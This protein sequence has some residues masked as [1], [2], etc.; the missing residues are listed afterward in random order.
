MAFGLEVFKEVVDKDGFW[1]RRH[2]KDEAR[3]DEFKHLNFCK[4]INKIFVENGWGELFLVLLII[5]WLIF[6]HDV[7]GI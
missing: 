2:N 3:T 4:I 5:L 1:I 6:S 7:V